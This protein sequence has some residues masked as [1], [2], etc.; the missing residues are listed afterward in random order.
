MDFNLLK[1]EIKG[2]AFEEIRSDTGTYLEAVILNK[3]MDRL[4]FSL[5][6]HLGAP[7]FPSDAALSTQAED[8]IKSFG[9]INN[10]Q[11]LY[12]KVDGQEA[13]FAMFWPWQD[14]AHTTLKL[15]LTSL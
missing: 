3:N 12:L 6:Q 10:G 1:N 4:V 5:K 14:K 8:V 15:G 9:G 13:I 2:I 7:V 11:T